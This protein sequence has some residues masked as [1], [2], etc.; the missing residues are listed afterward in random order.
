M[1]KLSLKTTVAIDPKSA[2]AT[3]ISNGHNINPSRDSKPLL[4]ALPNL[5]TAKRVLS[6]PKFGV[7]AAQTNSLNQFK[8]T[9]H[10]K[11]VPNK[12]TYATNAH[13]LIIMG[14]LAT[15]PLL[16]TF[17]TET[18]LPVEPLTRLF[19]TKNSTF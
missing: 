13:P 4:V 15:R 9:Q 2:R 10:G 12:Q 7:A 18:N 17:E 6:N 16:Q 19:P 8:T 5:R 11:L 1:H 14:V 3:T